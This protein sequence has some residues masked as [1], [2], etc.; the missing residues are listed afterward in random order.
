MATGPAGAPHPSR[1]P[2]GSLV[3]TAAGWLWLC[4]GGPG[5]HRAGPEHEI[6]ADASHDRGRQDADL[7]EVDHRAAA[8]GE[9]RD[10]QAHGES[11]PAEPGHAVDVAPGD[12]LGQ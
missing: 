8:E 12:P 9:T 10:E 6:A 7:G 3:P 5:A 11:D 4:L 1:T 2:G